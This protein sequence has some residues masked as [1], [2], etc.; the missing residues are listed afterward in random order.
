MASSF[1]H[2][3][4]TCAYWHPLAAPNSI[5]SELD[6]P[7][8]RATPAIGIP[9]LAGFFSG[10]LPVPLYAGTAVLGEV[11]L[12]LTLALCRFAA[13]ALNCLVPHFALQCYRV[14]VDAR[15]R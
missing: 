13:L 3:L 5:A 10:R 7:R 6:S 4:G 12:R 8:L 15:A 11:L 2:T 9:S 1:K 14:C